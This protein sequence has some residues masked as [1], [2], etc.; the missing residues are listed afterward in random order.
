MQTQT[1]DQAIE[2]LNQRIAAIETALR[3]TEDEVDAQ[4]LRC[5]LAAEYAELVRAWDGKFRGWQLWVEQD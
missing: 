4:R 2:R 1:I 5:I 3:Q